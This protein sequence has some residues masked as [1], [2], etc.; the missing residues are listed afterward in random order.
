MTEDTP[1]SDE[2][3]TAWEF[4]EH[5][6]MNVFLTGRA[7][8]GKTT[9]LR[10]LRERSAKTM[11]VVAPSGVAAVNAGG[12]TIHSFFQ[13]PLSP[14]IPGVENHEKFNFAKDKL[15][16][17]RSLDLLVIDEISMVRSDTL[18]A[19]D[20]ALRR[21]RRDSRPFGGVQ[22]LMIG[23]LRQLSPIVTQADARL[24][25]GHYATPYFFGSRALA[26][27]PYVTVQLTRVFRQHDGRFIDLLNHV[28]DNNLTPGDLGLLASRVDRSFTPP[29]GSGYIRLTTHNQQADSY[30]ERE[31]SRLPGPEV[32]SRARIEG[33]FPETSF[34]TSQ[35]LRLKAGAQVMFIKNDQS[36]EPRYYNGK[37]GVVTYAGERMVRVKCGNE[38]DEI[39]VLPQQWEN[40]VYTVNEQTNEIETTVQGVFSQIPLRLAW[41]ITIHKSQGLTFDRAVIDAGAS[42]APGQVYVALSRCRTLE[43]IVL[44]TPIAAGSVMSDVSVNRYLSEQEEATAASLFQLPRLK[45]AYELGLLRSLFM[46]RDMGDVYSR[47]VNTI[48]TTFSKMY[49]GIYA[50]HQSA[51]EEFRSRVTEVSDRWLRQL[52]GVSAAMLADGALQTRI[53]NGARYFSDTLADIFDGWIADTA[54]VKSDNK[55]ATRRVQ[56]LLSEFMILLRGRVNLYRAVAVTGFEASEFPQQRRRAMLAAT[57][58]RHE[59]T[60]SGREAK[61]RERKKRETKP[62]TRRVTLDMFNNGRSIADIARE[63]GLQPLT[64]CSHLATYIAT[65]TV[66]LEDVLPRDKVELITA[67]ISKAGP[68]AG[69]GDVKMQLPESVGYGD[70]RL[71]MASL[72]PETLS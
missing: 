36:A 1:Q 52:D 54:M 24:L 70:I 67:A 5:T 59:S 34:P 15:R 46:F 11:V 12:V 16:I 71:V 41:A 18:D 48:G 33:T 43:G 25:Q 8:T 49:A 65:G 45:Q 64:I 30:N 44:A 60:R 3:R 47:L 2:L 14:Y 69:I 6:G 63:R 56:E 50:K 21:Y 4:V 31:L 13:L 57:S 55:Q 37:I 58:G 29:A 10:R 23:D 17:I 39:E 40:A 26:Q 68:G 35:E 53:R 27:T 28:R 20:N 72:P 42:F 61:K 51:I 9:F 22:L 7:G 32:I 62:D 38:P 19:V 66:R